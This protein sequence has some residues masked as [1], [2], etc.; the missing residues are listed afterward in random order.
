MAATMGKLLLQRGDRGYAEKTCPQ[1]EQK[2]KGRRTVLHAE[3]EANASPLSE[4]RLA[5]TK[6]R[7]SANRCAAAHKKPNTPMVFSVPLRVPP[8]TKSRSPRPSAPSADKKMF[9][10]TLRVTSRIKKPF[11][12]YPAVH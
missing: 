1:R 4:P 10:A 5:Q 6:R 8:W 3:E 9:F 2:S 12:A 11:P 7:Q